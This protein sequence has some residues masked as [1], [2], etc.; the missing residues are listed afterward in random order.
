MLL[1]LLK[2]SNSCRLAQFLLHHAHKSWK[3]ASP[4]SAEIF[5]RPWN[6]TT[7]WEV[8]SLRYVI[9]HLVFDILLYTDKFVKKSF[10]AKWVF[11]QTSALMTTDNSVQFLYLNKSSPGIYKTTYATSSCHNVFNFS[12]FQHFCKGEVCDFVAY[13]RSGSKTF[14]IFFNLIK[15]KVV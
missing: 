5:H 13:C 9:S 7:W 8:L 1:F 11:Y 12:S 6:K 10:S 15:R 4:I 2:S 3:S 14:E